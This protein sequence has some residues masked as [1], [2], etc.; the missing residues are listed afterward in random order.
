MAKTQDG[1]SKPWAETASGRGD[2][3][4]VAFG[5]V[6]RRHREAARQSQE[7]LAESAGLHPTAVSLLERG[8]RQ[9]TLGVVINLARAL[10]IDVGM[11]VTEVT[12]ALNGGGV[13]A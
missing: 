4:A 10:G 2:D 7:R 8:R 9:P 11:L 6:L 13:R 3:V 5:A 12:G 1:N